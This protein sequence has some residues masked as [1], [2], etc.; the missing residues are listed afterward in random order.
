MRIYIGKMNHVA[1]RKITNHKKWD[2]EEKKWECE[3]PKFERK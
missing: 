2:Y 3:I 1:P